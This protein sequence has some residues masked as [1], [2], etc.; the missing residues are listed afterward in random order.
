[1]VKPFILRVLICT[2]PARFVSE[3][4]RQADFDKNGGIDCV[5]T[6]GRMDES[7]GKSSKIGEKKRTRNGVFNWG[8][9]L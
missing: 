4:F 5:E 6:L 7:W 9:H 8:N 3:A 2:W 1:M